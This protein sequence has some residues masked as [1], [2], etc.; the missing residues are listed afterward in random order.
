M[1]TFILMLAFLGSVVTT[2]FAGNEL[3]NPDDPVIYTYTHICDDGTM[4]VA[5]S[6]FEWDQATIAAWHAAAANECANQ[7]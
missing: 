7:H 6:N 1:K 4:L 2:A 5:V 3:P